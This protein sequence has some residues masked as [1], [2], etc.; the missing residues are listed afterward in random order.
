MFTILGT[1]EGL[2]TPNEGELQQ[3]PCRWQSTSPH[4][5]C[6]WPHKAQEGDKIHTLGSQCIL[7]STP[8]SR[9]G[10]DDKAKGLDESEAKNQGRGLS[11][12]IKDSLLLQ[13]AT[14]L[15]PATVS[16]TEPLLC[17]RRIKEQG[18][19]DECV[20]VRPRLSLK[21]WPFELDHF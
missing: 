5:G 4:A 2:P 8:C 7:W 10:V 1:K 20:A 6:Q 18:C 14:S 11:M 3:T 13:C 16:K 19:D 9:S 21:L 12:L 15:G 17:S